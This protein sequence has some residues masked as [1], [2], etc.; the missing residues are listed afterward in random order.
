MSWFAPQKQ[1][2]VDPDNPTA[3]EQFP[4]SEHNAM[5]AYLKDK[6]INKAVNAAA[7]GD[8]KILVYDLASDSFVF[9]TQN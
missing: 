7:I 2:A 9:E 1:A 4:F 5:V 8:D 3:D 6:I